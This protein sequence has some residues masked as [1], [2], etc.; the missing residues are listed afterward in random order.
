MIV[1]EKNDF[2]LS[3]NASLAAAKSCLDWT[4]NGKDQLNCLNNWSAELSRIITQYLNK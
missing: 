4:T 3:A 2:G 1:V